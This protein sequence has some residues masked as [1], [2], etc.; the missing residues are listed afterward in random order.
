MSSA[1]TLAQPQRHRACKHSEMTTATR[2]RIPHRSVAF[3]I[4]CYLQGSPKLLA[5]RQWPELKQTIPG[6]TRSNVFC[7]T[8]RNMVLIVKAT[9]PP[10]SIAI[11]IQKSSSRHSSE[12]CAKNAVYAPR[13]QLSSISSRKEKH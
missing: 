1:G 4:S 6:G 11:A 9:L 3:L 12:R 7:R 13:N 2:R 8:G 5:E 10:A